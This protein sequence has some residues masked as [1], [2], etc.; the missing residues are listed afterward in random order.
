MPFPDI[1]LIRHG[2]TEFNREGRIQG[3]GNS[4]LTELGR[5]QAAAYGRLLAERFQPLAPFALY[6]SPAGRC[7]ETTA[8]AAAAAGLDPGAFVVDERLKEKGYGR[9]EGMTRPEIAGGGEERELAAMDA[10]PWGH[11][12]PGGGETL[13]EVMERTRRWLT[14]LN[15][16]QPVV[17]VSHG[18]TGRTLIRS[19]LALEA[20]EALAIAMRQDVVFH[21]SRRGLDVIETGADMS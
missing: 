12:P 15:P 20:E 13:A 10:D 5:S 9:W 3:Q 8:L 1:I 14:G 19:Y 11:R 2:Q 17:A 18:G 16:A 21:L 4:V 7:A 6:R